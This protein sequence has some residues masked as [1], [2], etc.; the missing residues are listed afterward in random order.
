MS[1]H[2]VAAT[3][4]GILAVATALSVGHLVAGLLSIPDASPF[5]AVG[6][7]IGLIARPGRRGGCFGSAGRCRP[8]STR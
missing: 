2:S 1:K 8:V 6:N 7:E 5:L 3:A 4:S